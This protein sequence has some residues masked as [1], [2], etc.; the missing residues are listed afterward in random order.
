M[1]FVKQNKCAHE[2]PATAI[3][4]DNYYAILKQI[5]SFIYTEDLDVR[6]L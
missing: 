3:K 5:V 2:I 4:M 1:Q 6:F